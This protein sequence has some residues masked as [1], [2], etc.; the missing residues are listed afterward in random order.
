[1][2]WGGRGEDGGSEVGDHA[3]KVGWKEAVKGRGVCVRGG[4]GGG[5]WGGEGTFQLCR[6]KTKTQI[7]NRVETICSLERVGWGGGIWFFLRRFFSLQC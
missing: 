5:R 2:E 7:Q 4:Q 6:Q 3:R 1:M